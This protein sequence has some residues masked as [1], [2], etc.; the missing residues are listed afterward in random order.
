MGLTQHSVQ[1]GN[2]VKSDFCYREGDKVGGLNV[3]LLKQR[4]DNS[5]YAL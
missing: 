1:E 2:Y 3:E 4:V 5:R